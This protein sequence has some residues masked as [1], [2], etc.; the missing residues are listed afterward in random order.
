MGIESEYLGKIMDIY[1]GYH[2]DLGT[3]QTWG[4]LLEPHVWLV[5]VESSIKT[6]V[7]ICK[8]FSLGAL[9]CFT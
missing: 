2:V 4:T 7:T 3:V 1:L 6:M 9:K 5:G 8:D